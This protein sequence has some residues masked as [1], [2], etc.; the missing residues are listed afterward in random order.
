MMN[1]IILVGR[2]VKDLEI[3]DEEKKFAKLILAVN[4]NFKNTDG[5]YETDFIPC[6]LFNGIAENAINYCKKNDIVGI[7][8]RLQN[9]NG[10][11]EIIAEKVSF[12][13]N[14]SDKVKQEK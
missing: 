3:K 13:S 9:T 8:G 4:R 1:Q 7:K 10:N 2:I 11:I 12:L 14:N 5:V 6:I